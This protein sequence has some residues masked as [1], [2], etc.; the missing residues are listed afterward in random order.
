M[1]FSFEILGAWFGKFWSET[2]IK[3]CQKMTTG[4]NIDESA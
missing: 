4:L 1:F 2:N 3:S